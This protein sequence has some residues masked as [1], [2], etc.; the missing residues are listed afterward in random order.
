M[1]S[2]RGKKGGGD[3]E[4][5]RGGE[6]KQKKMGSRTGP[7]RRWKTGFWWLFP[8]LKDRKG[9]GGGKLSSTRVIRSTPEMGR[10][11]KA[12]TAVIGFE[13]QKIPGCRE[14]CFPGG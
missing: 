10:A 1:G 11:K 9:R 7:G 5:G 4:E 12:K 13:F 6:N 3:V 14:R 2:E 8:G